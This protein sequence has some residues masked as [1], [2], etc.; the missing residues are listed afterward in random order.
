MTGT[1]QQRLE[2]GLK[3]ELCRLTN[4]LLRFYLLRNPKIKF[5]KLCG[6]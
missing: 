4:G 5:N 3:F 2:L 6:V 1:G